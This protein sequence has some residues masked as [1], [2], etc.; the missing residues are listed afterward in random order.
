MITKNNYTKGF[1]YAS[2]LAFMAF[3][4]YV[5]Y[6]N[7]EVFYAAH[8]RSEFL[9]G[10]PFFDTLMSRPFGL[11]QYVGAW[12]TQY[13]YAPAVGTCLLVAVWALIFGV[14]VKAFRLQGGAVALMLL[15]VA[16]LLTS[17]VDLGYWIYIMRENGYWFSY[18][19]AYLVMLLLLWAARCT[20]RQWHLVWYLAAVVLFPVLGWF[21]MLFVL[22]LVLSD[23]L[24]WRE[25]VGVLLLV[26]VGSTWHAL[27]YSEMKLQDALM[28]GFPRFVTPSDSCDRLSIPFWML[29]AVSVLI[30]LCGKYLEKA[31]VPV[32]SAVVGIAFTVSL[33]FQ[34]QNYIN[35]MRMVRAAQTDNWEEV[36]SVASE[37]STQTTS[38]SMLKNVALMYEGDLLDR[39]FKIG[40]N[41]DPIYNPDSLHVSLLEIAAPIIY[42]N[43]GMIN[44]A[45]RLS[46]ECAVQAGFSPFYLKMIARCACATGEMNLEKRFTTQLHHHS[47]YAHWQPAFA[48]E[49]VRELQ[50]CYSDEIT[51]VENSYTYLVD[52]ISQWKAAGSKLV[53]EQALLYSMIGCN[54]RRFWPSLRRFLNTHQGDVFPESAQEAYIL[55]MDKAPEEKRMMVP[56]SQEIYDR[57][58]QFWTDV[59]KRVMSGKNLLQT[60]EELRE[61]W[62][63]TYWYYTI[64]GTKIR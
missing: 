41:N 61:Q 48:S 57:Y 27:L 22:C 24:S 23:K 62:G 42:Y 53:S 33:M 8:D 47:G 64:F 28:G 31:Y 29:G 18:S 49:K 32:L 45:M 55:Y 40:N 12:L 39:S 35:E 38:M 2:L 36:L 6:I 44:E 11:M 16:F 9:F 37:S 43:Y 15:P 5:L 52:E 51:G 19:V 30:P 54:S 17:V 21:A 58:K 25:L 46:Y 50:H 34:D 63:D 59:E 56:V 14:G 13:F 1:L 20:P 26:F 10:S 3:V 7:Q 4:A 60:G